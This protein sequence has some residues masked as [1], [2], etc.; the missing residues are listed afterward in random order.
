MDAAR[1][2]GPVR[3]HHFFHRNG[4]VVCSSDDERRD[5]EVWLVGVHGRRSCGP[6]HRGIGDDPHPQ[7]PRSNV[8]NPRG[9]VGWRG[10]ADVL[11]EQPVDPLFL[12][13]FWHSAGQRGGVLS[14]QHCAQFRELW[15]H[16]LVHGRGP[17]CKVFGRRF[18]RKNW[19]SSGGQNPHLRRWHRS[20]WISMEHWI[21]PWLWVLST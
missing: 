16:F 3:V 11:R 7:I 20:S 5:L 1:R 13:A 2:L 19:G 10:R 15:L 17:G 4:P 6:R 21:V 9:G 14:I 12:R 18:D 8:D